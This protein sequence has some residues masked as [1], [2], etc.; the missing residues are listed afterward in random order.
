MLRSEENQDGY[1][2]Q[3][4]FGNERAPAEI[5]LQVGLG[6]GIDRQISRGQERKENQREKAA[7]DRKRSQPSGQKSRPDNAV[8]DANSAGG[9]RAEHHPLH[10]RREKTRDTEDA[11]PPHLHFIFLRVVLPKNERGPAQHDAQQHHGEGNVQGR[12][13]RR[14][15]FGPRREQE[16]YDEDQP[17]MIRFPDRGDRIGNRFALLARPRAA[18][19]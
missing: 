12:H 11:A 8:L 10:E 14:E 5:I 2:R 7:G 18:R 9:E 19:Q 1:R 13:H 15:G 4:Q 17:N 6:G 16:D 3:R